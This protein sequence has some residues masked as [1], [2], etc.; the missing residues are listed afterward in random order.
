MAKL[1][2]KNIILG[3]CGSISAYK[4]PNLVREFIKNDYNV[5]CIMTESSKQFVTESALSNV[6]KNKVISN[7]FD[8]DYSNDGA[9]HIH[10]AHNID[11]CVIAPCSATTLGKL[12]NGICDN[13]LTTFVIA[14]PKEI[15]VIIAPAMDFTMLEHPS[16]QLNIN[17]LKSY[18][19]YLIEPEFG[20]LSSGLIG[21][22]RLPEEKKIIQ[23]VNIRL[24]KLDKVVIDDEENIIKNNKLSDDINIES[25]LINLKRENSKLRGKKLLITLGST[26]EKIDDV[27]FI[28]NHS[29]GKMGLAIIEEA[30]ERGLDI[31]AVCGKIQVE[32]PEKV[33]VINVESADQMYNVT[34]SNKDYQD[35][36][37]MTAAVADYKVENHY[38]GKIKKDNNES[39]T[40]NLIPNKDILKSIGE[41]KTHNQKVIGFALETSNETI[42][43]QNKLHS[44]NADMIVLN[45]LNK[46]N[47]VFGS[48][49][50]QITI[51]T[52]TQEKD[53]AKMNKRGCAIEIFNEIE[54]LL[55]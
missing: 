49:E 8:K 2:N 46:D 24:S 22:G 54:K 19:Y 28:S 5:Q 15:P 9:W 30:I 31:T 27:R 16:V 39:M 12:A 4:T 55:K 29:S 41:I 53:F 14:L 35:L 34:M 43:A 10:L 38:E 18:G 11:A 33:R 1:Q 52:N 13:A 25:D 50:N 48:D 17:K 21:K 36:F 3:I 40:L 45:K 44:K 20:E 23:F 51:L 32:L 7:L 42:N 47:N 6:S 37:I 26:I